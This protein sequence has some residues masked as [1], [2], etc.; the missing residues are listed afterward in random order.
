MDDDLREFHDETK[1]IISEAD[2]FRANGLE[3]REDIGKFAALMFKAGFTE[4]QQE[5]SRL[6]KLAA[7]NGVVQ[8]K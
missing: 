6:M 1:R 5:M 7:F 3:T 4:C 8:R 2:V